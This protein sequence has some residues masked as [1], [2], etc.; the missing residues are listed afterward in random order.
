MLN[1]KNQNK[2][3]S[4]GLRESSGSANINII[5]NGTTIKGSIDSASDTR[6]AGRLEGNVTVRGTVAITEN[7]ALIGSVLAENI[8]ISGSVEGEI[9]ASEKVTLTSSANVEGTIRAD[10]LV[11]EEGAIF[12][13]ECQTG[14]KSK[15]ISSNF[16]ST[17]NGTDEQLA[18]QL[19]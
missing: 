5:A 4:T 15:A 11:I 19:A 17:S 14:P 9:T 7:G 3:L 16:V 13:G 1:K 6:L 12:N 18:K 2:P 10:Q 8:N